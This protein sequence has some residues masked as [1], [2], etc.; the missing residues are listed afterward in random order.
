MLLNLT[1]NDLMLLEKHRLERLRSL[2]NDTLGLCYL[3]L[4][5]QNYL[6]IHCSEAWIVDALMADLNQLRSSVWTVTGANSLCLCFAEEEV[7]RIA[8]RKPVK[9]NRARDRRSTEAAN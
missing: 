4:D 7:Y 9:K 8:T 5:Q 1:T 6:K 2:F 3:Q